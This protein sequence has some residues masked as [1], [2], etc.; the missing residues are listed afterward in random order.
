MTA[1]FDK[2]LD[3]LKKDSQQVIDEFDRETK[4]LED[5]L[6]E[7]LLEEAK[8]KYRHQKDRIEKE[9]HD[10]QERQ[11]LAYSSKSRQEVNRYQL[12]LIE[13]VIADAKAYLNDL[14]DQEYVDFLKFQLQQA[15]D[16]LEIRVPKKRESLVKSEN[17]GVDIIVD[18]SLVDGFVL[19]A[20]NRDIN[21][22]F[23]KLIE[24]YHDDLVEFVRKGLFND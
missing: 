5:D 13:E 3:A 7:S 10:L 11:L 20:S 6:R 19:I 8:R 12:Q 16:V 4:V 9:A 17:F 14:S 23:N 18:D 22:E 2:L 15:S 24:F 21:F 1:N